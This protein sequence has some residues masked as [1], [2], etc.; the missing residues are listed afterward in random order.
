MGGHSHIRH[1]KVVRQVFFFLIQFPTIV[2]ER[3]DPCIV[4]CNWSR[5][6]KETISKQSAASFRG[7][8]KAL[9][10]FMV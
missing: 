9:D 5:Q 1:H 2:E 8:E 7:R 6:L 3:L 4:I 10:Q